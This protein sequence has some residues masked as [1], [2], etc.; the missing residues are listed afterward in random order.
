MWAGGEVHVL[1][2]LTFSA[3]EHSQFLWISGPLQNFIQRKLAQSFSYPARDS[4]IAKVK[5]ESHKNSRT[6]IVKAYTVSCVGMGV[7]GLA[8]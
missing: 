1:Y 7:V 6:V 3:D 2:P 5:C 4:T 8:L